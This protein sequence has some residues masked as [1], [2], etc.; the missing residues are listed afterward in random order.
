MSVERRQRVLILARHMLDWIHETQRVGARSSEESGVGVT[1]KRRHSRCRGTGRVL[2]EGPD[3]KPCHFCRREQDRAEEEGRQWKGPRHK[4]CRPCLGCDLGW[5]RS[6]AEASE[7]AYVK[8]GETEPVEDSNRRA[9]ARRRV[10][11]LL[12]QLEVQAKQREGK[13]SAE[14]PLLMAVR[15]KEAQYRHGDYQALNSAL[16]FLAVVNPA[17]YA[18]FVR[19]EVEQD[20]DGVPPRV[21]LDAIADQLAVWM[22]G[23]IVLPGD[24]EPSVEAKVRKENFW[25]GRHPS[26]ARQRAERDALICELRLDGWGTQRLVEHFNLDRRRIQ[27]ILKACEEVE[28]A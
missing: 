9:A 19:W 28:A 4:V 8:V 21:L 10:D 25:R 3:A 23:R 20:A 22:P 18:I 2:G 15:M 14:T 11:S 17:H 12:F 13:E 5:V 16:L 1:G 27:Q 24:L 6:S 7:D 26:T